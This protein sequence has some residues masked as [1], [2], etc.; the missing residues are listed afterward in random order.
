MTELEKALIA[1]SVPYATKIVTEQIIPKLGKFFSASKLKRKRKKGLEDSIQKSLKRLYNSCN[2]LQ[3]IAFQ[4]TPKRLSSLYIPLELVDIEDE[5]IQIDNFV[6]IFERN[7]VITIFDSAG[8]GKTTVVKKLVSESIVRGTT[9]PALYELRKFREG[10]NLLVE[11]L[12]VI[13]APEETSESIFDEISWELYFDGLDEAPENLACEI[14]SQIHKLHESHPR[15]RILVTSRKQSEASDLL[16]YKC[17]NIR[18]L[19][20][21]E[22]FDLIK[23]YDS[24][25]ELGGELIKAISASKFKGIHEYLT[26]PLYISLLYCAFR[27]KKA[28][29][30]KMCLFYEQVYNALFD[31]HDLTKAANYRHSLRTKLDSQDF[32]E[33][34]RRLAFVCFADEFKIE[35]TKLD[36]EAKIQQV[37]SDIDH[38]TFKAADFIHDATVGVPLLVQEGNTIRWSHKSLLEFFT[39]LFICRDSEEFGHKFLSALVGHSR[40]EKYRHILEICSDLDYR[41]FRNSVAPDLLTRYLS[42]SEALSLKITNKRIDNQDVEHRCFET[43]GAKTFIQICKL[44][45]RKDLLPS[46]FSNFD[47]VLNEGDPGKVHQFNLL[48]HPKSVAACIYRETSPDFWLLRLVSKREGTKIKTALTSDKCLDHLAKKETVTKSEK[49]NEVDDNPK[50]L[51]NN[52]KNFPLLTGLL[53]IE[54]QNRVLLKADAQRVLAEITENRSARSLD[55]IYKQ[56]LDSQE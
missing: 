44:D 22:A 20:K 50:S 17:Y 15:L 46:I 43:F 25:G 19:Q 53:T 10:Q 40:A 54:G 35:Y 49:V 37:C 48:I 23:K 11:I 45:K 7:Q 47:G 8:M 12:K 9:I 21:D 51:L 30:E 4:G 56:M 42:F 34:L 3:T 38:L 1:E 28:L 2:Q 13:G 14:I 27:H 5:R 18:P 33:V 36:L 29:P 31:Q 26:N 32:A 24:G 52:S 55:S 39:A 41:L 16:R 6:N